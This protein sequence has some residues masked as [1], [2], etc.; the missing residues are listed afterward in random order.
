MNGSTPKSIVLLRILPGLVAVVAFGVVLTTEPQ[1]PLIAIA[2]IVAGSVAAL[3]G[4][5]A[6]VR[7]K[8]S[9]E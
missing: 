2:G 4:L 5:V 9:K 7:L 3:L 6:L 1:A 8:R